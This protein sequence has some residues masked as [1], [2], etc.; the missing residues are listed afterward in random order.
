MINV[1]VVYALPERQRVIE[2]QV[3]DDCTALAAVQRSGITDE[4]SEIDWNTVVLGIFGKT[5]DV[6][7][8]TG[9]REGDRIEIYRPLLVDPKIV[10]RERARRQ[11]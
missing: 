4:L 10:R 7:A 3:E 9:L 2:L 1:A 5:I 6:P 11:R 8:Q